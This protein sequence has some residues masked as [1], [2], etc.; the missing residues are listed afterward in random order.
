M[1]DLAE[2]RLANGWRI[3]EAP[4]KVACRLRTQCRE[5]RC[6]SRPAAVL[7]SERANLEARARSGAPISCEHRCLTAVSRASVGDIDAQRRR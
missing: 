5:T 4:G 2:L 7:V 1:M 3:T 6:A